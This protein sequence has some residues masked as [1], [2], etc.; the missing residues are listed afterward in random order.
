MKGVGFY[1][2]KNIIS[3]VISSLYLRAWDSLLYLGLWG[4]GR[5]KRA[6]EL[7]IVRRSC[8]ISV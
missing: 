8:I 4:I 1:F 6:Q 2:L 3:F 5:G 7:D